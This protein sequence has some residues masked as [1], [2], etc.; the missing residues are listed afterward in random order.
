MKAQNNQENN[1]VSHE[2][3]IFQTGVSIQDI[4]SQN[5]NKHLEFDPLR[6]KT[7]SKLRFFNLL[8]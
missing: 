3:G 2:N 1:E 8:Q 7:E 5:L 4:S 6:S